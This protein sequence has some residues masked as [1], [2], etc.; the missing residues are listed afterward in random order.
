MKLLINETDDTEIQWCIDM[1]TELLHRNKCNRR[2]HILEKWRE[3]RW[4]PYYNIITSDL[5][6][7]HLVS[8][9]RCVAILAIKL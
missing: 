6:E 4:Y 1:L 7:M 2:L 5:L 9:G 8:K 3:D